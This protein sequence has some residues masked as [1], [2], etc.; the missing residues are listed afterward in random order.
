MSTSITPRKRNNPSQPAQPPQKKKN[1]QAVKE[2]DIS[3][4]PYTFA[5]D[6]VSIITPVVSVEVKQ[7]ILDRLKDDVASK[8]HK[9]WCRGRSAVR[10]K[11]NSD[12]ELTNENLKEV[13]ITCADR[14][15]R[16]RLIVGE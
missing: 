4:V 16:S 10:K 5:S 8:L 9:G 3:C 12:G 13:S 14:I 11:I 6:G 1:R 7:L 2:Y 15:V